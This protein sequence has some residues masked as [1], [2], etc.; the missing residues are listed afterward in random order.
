ME[1]SALND[2]IDTVRM[3]ISDVNDKIDR[4]KGL[5]DKSN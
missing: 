3:E 4:I 2:K 1:I 5:M